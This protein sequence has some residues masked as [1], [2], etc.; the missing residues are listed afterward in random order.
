MVPITPQRPSGRHLN[1]SSTFDSTLSSSSPGSTSTLP[2]SA[3]TPYNTVIPSTPDH[4]ISFDT[5]SAFGSSSRLT[6][7]AGGDMRM[8]SSPSR[9]TPT[10]SRHPSSFSSYAGSSHHLLPY[11]PPIRDP[12]IQ[13]FSIPS[14][15]RPVPPPLSLGHSSAS[16]P[17]AKSIDEDIGKGTFEAPGHDSGPDANTQADRDALRLQQLGYDPVLGRDYTFWSSLAIS[18]LNIGCIQG[19]VYAVSGAYSFGGPLMI[20]VMWPLSGIWT[21]FLTLS[22]AE[23]ASVYPVSGAMASWAWKVA[24]GGVGWERWW[25]WLMGGVVLGGHVANVLLVTWQLVNIV[26][27]IMG[28]S[29]DYDYKPW[30]GILFY[31]TVLF[32]C[33][34][35]GSQAWGRSHRFWIC[36]GIYGVCVWLILC[37][38]LLASSGAR[39]SYSVSP[40]LFLNNTGWESR[41]YVFILGW[42]YCT[43]ASGHDASAHMAEETQNPSRNVPN[44]MVCAMALTYIC[45]MISISLLLLSINPEDAAT[46]AEHTFAVGFILTQAINRPAAIGICTL[47]IFTLT[48]Q[49]MAQLQASSRFVFAMARD[50]AMPFAASIRR[51]NARKQPIV[52]HWLVIALCVPFSLLVLAGKG[53]VYSVLAVTASTLSYLGYTTPVLLYLLSGKDLRTEGRSSWSLRTKSKIIGTV[54]V[55]YGIAVI[56]LSMAPGEYPV[57]VQSISWGPVI[58][59]GTVAVCLLTWRF[60]GIKHYSGPIKAVTKWETGVEI[61]LQ[62]AI[63]TQR[64]RP[65]DPG[66]D[67]DYFGPTDPGSKARG[68]IPVFVQTADDSERQTSTRGT[69]GTGSEWTDATASSASG[70]TAT[71]AEMG[72]DAGMEMRERLDSEDL[73]GVVEI[74]RESGEGEE[75][76]R[77]R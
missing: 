5:E 29:F 60:Y 40:S 42:E 68:T 47:L 16:G 44:A 28:L 14:S 73:R 19:T 12:Q 10:S 9:P 8:D 4:D 22:L 23:L 26:H 50:N 74:L 48:V 30:H 77:G 57:T 6:S 46:V 33:G 63:T 2:S 67:A 7:R 31:L 45:G 32:V 13:S 69:G 38:S 70:Q 49:I 37:V 3:P 43:I 35:V 39:H 53:P 56:S 27:G 64:S 21:I 24:R 51:T 72:S 61:D 75:R 76:H 62:S 17:D 25:A 1:S 34:L 20:L 65:T 71:R 55:C 41:P 36:A 58:L 52:A 66:A 15:D 11:T 59:V 54:G 18:W